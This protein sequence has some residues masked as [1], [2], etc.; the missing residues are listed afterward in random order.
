ME[1]IDYYRAYKKYKRKYKQQQAMQMNGGQLFHNIFKRR[2]SRKSD[3]SQSEL[4][5]RERA[6]PT[7]AK[8][9][10]LQQRASEMGKC[11]EANRA[12]GWSNDKFSRCRDRVVNRYQMRLK[13]ENLSNFDANQ[14]Q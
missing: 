6:S 14:T 10:A 3:S 11:R 7:D 1:N 4:M 9:N 13:G 8:Y 12:N 5:D 2:S